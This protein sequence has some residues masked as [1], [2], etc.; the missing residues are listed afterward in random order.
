MKVVELK[1]K[2]QNLI[3]GY[4]YYYYFHYENLDLVEEVVVV[5]MKLNFV[6]DVAD[7]LGY[8][9][10]EGVRYR[11]GV[12]LQQ[13]LLVAGP[14]DQKYH[15]LHGCQV[16]VY[17]FL[18]TLHEQ[19]GIMAFH[20]KKFKIPCKSQVPMEKLVC[21]LTLLSCASLFAPLARRS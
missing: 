9:H 11:D 3:D 19:Q 8:V 13:C 10:R 17:K 6:D 18:R 4:Y 21:K 5:G 2:T 1:L 20:P 7:S 15:D 12:A 16:E 14:Y